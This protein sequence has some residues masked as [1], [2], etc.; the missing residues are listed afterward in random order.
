MEAG[1]SRKRL[2]RSTRSCYQCRKRKVKCQLTDE[3]VETCAECKK[4]GTQC[5]LQAPDTGLSSES[6]PDLVEKQER[7]LR[8]ERIELLLKKLVDAQE[9]SRPADTS[10]SESEIALPASFWD[11]VL[12]HSTTSGILP[13]IEGHDLAAPPAPDI[14][15]L[16]AKQSLVA[17]LPSA[18]DAVTIA[19]NSTAWRWGTDNPPGSVLNSS[20]TSRLIEIPTI[21][22]GSAMHVAKTLLLFAV[23]MQQLPASFDVNFLESKNVERAI[24]LIVERVKSFILPQEDEACSLDGLECLTL[25]SLIHINDGALRKAWMAFRRVLDIARLKGLQHSYSVVGRNSSSEDAALH[26]RLWLSTVCGDCYC[27]LLLGLDPALGTT[28][29]GLESEAWNDPFADDEANVQRRICLIAARVAQRNV[30]G[31]YQD[32]QTLR[33]IDESLARLEGSTPP[34]WWRVPAFRE[35]RPIDSAKEPN[36]VI[37]QLWFSQVQI[38]AHIPIAFGKSTNDS[39]KSLETCME[40]SR[41]TLHRYLSLQHARDHLSR[42]R[43]VDQSGFIGAV[44]L[45]LAKVQLQQHNVGQTSWRYD[46]DRALLEQ[47]VESFEAIGKTCSREHVPREISA[48]ISTMLRIVD[49]GSGDSLAASSLSDPDSSLMFG[50]PSDTDAAL[51][52]KSGMYDIIKSSI[53]PM[54]DVE[55]PASHLL[56]ALLATKRSALMIPNQNQELPHMDPTL[57]FDNTI[58]PIVLQ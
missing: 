22:K 40:A 55:C 39:L 32:H 34:S 9:Q 23:Y 15:T 5:T 19:T 54:L 25:L 10:S 53:Q 48:I 7:G 29:F 18:Q 38:Y 47:V 20:D 12:L 3:N 13:P 17:L 26:R 31:C 11:D 45:I 58:D 36:R 28:P 8:L 33:E 44:V 4:S 6:S 56:N 50:T 42:C 43:T 16:D 49:S 52:T 1:H 41:I 46:S 51:G 30:A 21:S 37:C 27:S 2:R 57:T 14:F 24:E 35:A